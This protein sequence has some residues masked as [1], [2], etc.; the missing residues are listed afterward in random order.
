MVVIRKPHLIAL[1]EVFHRT[2]PHFLYFFAAHTHTALFAFF[3]APHRTFCY[4]GE[5][6]Y[7]TFRHFLPHLN[8]A[9]DHLEVIVMKTINHVNPMKVH[10]ILHDTTLAV[11]DTCIFE[12]IWAGTKKL[13]AAGSHVGLKIMTV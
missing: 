2:I 7:R 5:V 1:F 12:V 11:G 9:P 6:R 3:A 13:A 4:L 10:I 8:I